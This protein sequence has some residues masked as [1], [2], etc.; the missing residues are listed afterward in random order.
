MGKGTGCPGLAIDHDIC[1]LALMWKED[2]QWSG[3]PQ[4]EGIGCQ[5]WGIF[6]GE[7]QLLGM[8]GQLWQ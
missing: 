1:P 3:A 6:T 4:A 7:C 2:G 5:N 8:T